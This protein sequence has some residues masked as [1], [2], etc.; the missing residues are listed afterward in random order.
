MGAGVLTVA[1][2]ATAPAPAGV[3]AAPA[4]EAAAEAAAPA[5]TAPAGPVV[6]EE[7]SRWPLV[8]MIVPALIFLFATVITAGLHRHFSAHGH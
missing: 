6:A 7:R 4:P 5:V 3:E 8:G 2:L 1:Q